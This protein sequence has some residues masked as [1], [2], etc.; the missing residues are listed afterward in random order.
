MEIRQPCCCNPASFHSNFSLQI[1]LPLPGVC[2]ATH[3]PRSYS[4]FQTVPSK[5]WW[6]SRGETSGAAGQAERFAVEADVGSRVNKARCRDNQ[7]F[8]TMAFVHSY[9]TSSGEV[10]M[11]SFI[12]L[13][14]VVADDGSS[15]R[16]R[17]GF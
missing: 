3:Q 15:T 13:S 10:G 6:S 1:L 12:P 9:R 11:E 14:E 5:G 2:S 8:L 16:L 7:C 17:S 4:W